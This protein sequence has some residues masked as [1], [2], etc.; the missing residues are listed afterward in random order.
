MRHLLKIRITTLI[1]L[2]VFL[3]GC[4]AGNP[5]APPRF[6]M[7]SPMVAYKALPDTGSG[8]NPVVIGIAS[9]QV[10]EYLNRLQIVK[11]LD[12]TELAL[13]ECD[14]YS[15]DRSKIKHFYTEL[16]VQSEVIHSKEEI[17]KHH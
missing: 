1:L 3:A 15:I 4:L 13:G 10:P 16:T 7:L 11:R 6:Y 8:D 17:C 9:D 14:R 2:S 12:E 5:S